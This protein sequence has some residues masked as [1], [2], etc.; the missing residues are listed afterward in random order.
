[1]KQLGVMIIFMLLLTLACGDTDTPETSVPSSLEATVQALAS[2]NRFT[3]A[4]ETGP[5]FNIEAT[6]TYR[7]QATVQALFNATPIPSPTPTQDVRKVLSTPEPT[8]FTIQTGGSF[9]TA[10]NSLPTA[11]TVSS[12]TAAPLPTPR[13][14]P[15]PGCVGA[16]DGVRVSALVNGAIVETT[17][18]ENGRYSLMVEQND[19]TDFT[20]QTMT[21]M[22]GG[23]EAHQSIK[24]NQGAATELTLTAPNDDLSKIVTDHNHGARLKGGILAQP[25]P[26]HVVLGEVLVGIC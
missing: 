26:P 15:P 14:T 21:F 10:P 17:I 7:V 18:I 23:T 19:G 11:T 1:M 3:A 5:D 2:N 22:V 25:L 20:G 9:N 4:S 13:A 6:I 24:W 16:E 12:A 8:S